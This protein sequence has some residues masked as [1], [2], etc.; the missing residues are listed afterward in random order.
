MLSKLLNFYTIFNVRPLAAWLLIKKTVN[1]QISKFSVFNFLML[2]HC[3]LKTTNTACEGTSNCE[4]VITLLLTLFW[5]SFVHMHAKSFENICCSKEDLHHVLQVICVAFHKISRGFV[6]L[7]HWL[8]LFILV[9]IIIFTSAAISFS[10]Y[11]SFDIINIGSTHISCNCFRKM[12]SIFTDIT[13]LTLCRAN[14]WTG[15]YLISASVMK[16]LR[17]LLN[18][19]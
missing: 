3:F 16:E 15:F 10:L 13:K 8:K 1:Q 9:I 11:S 19:I 6:N 14:Q 5:F 7:K 4:G 12:R 18:R 17:R 2:S